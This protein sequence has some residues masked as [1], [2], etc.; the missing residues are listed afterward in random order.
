M[1]AI[2]AIGALGY[3]KPLQIPSRMIL[4]LIF[5]GL[6]IQ[7]KGVFENILAAIKSPPAQSSAAVA[8]PPLP[9]EI[10][11]HVTGTGGSGGGGP[12]GAI[13]G[14]VKAVAGLGIGG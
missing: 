12:L 9:A 6:L 7:N 8:E 10:P 14:G 1:G 13:L 4:F 2:L 11:V 5:L 3:W